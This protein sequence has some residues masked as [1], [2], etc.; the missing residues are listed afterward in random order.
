MNRDLDG[1]YFRVK[2]D[3]KWENVCFSDLTE[4][5]MDRVLENRSEEWL[6]NLCKTL[7]SRLKQIGHQFDINLE[8]SV[9]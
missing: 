9:I 4:L 8:E 1:V 7:G 3:G 5:E 2:R 6:R